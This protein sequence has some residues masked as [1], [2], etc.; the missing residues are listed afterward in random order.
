MGAMN[1]K[2][3]RL[4]RVGITVA[5]LPRM[6]AFYQG[7][8][9]FAPSPAAAEADPAWA[10]LLGAEGA[11]VRTARLRL[12]A[13]EIELTAFDPP[14]QPYPLGSTAADLWF[15]H[16]AVVTNDMAAAYGRIMRHGGATPITDGE[17][18]LLPPEAGGVTAY[19]F[20]DPEGHPVELI[21][22]PPGTGDAGWQ[23][24]TPGSVT[25]GYDHSAISVADAD[26][27]VA[28]YA[29]LLG[30]AQASRQ[31]NSGPAQ[32]RLDGLPGDVVDVVALHPAAA[33]TPHVELLA[34]RTPRGRPASGLRSRDVAAARLVLEVE[35]LPGLLG[36]LAD[37]GA[38]IAEPDPVP[39]ADGSRAALVHDPDRH[40]LVLI[41][42]V[43]EA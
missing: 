5:D 6:Q 16:I 42:G 25:L 36:T 30:L 7:A 18:Q 26:R 21:H 3:L 38:V 17:P 14:G 4:R 27:S 43:A 37:A 34:Y 23:H 8:L 35:N 20:R 2:V 32:E 10:R 33:S 40:A 31:V 19:K 12:G 11:G 28:F 13:Q 9:G 15:Q 29:G 24:A 39:L 41:E 1:G 22:F